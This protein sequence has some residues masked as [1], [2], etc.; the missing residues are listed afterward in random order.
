MQGFRAFP[1]LYSFRL[2]GI[3]VDPESEPQPPAT[4]S[5][6]GLLTVY[7]SRVVGTVRRGNYLR[8]DQIQGREAGWMPHS[9]GLT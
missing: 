2:I 9:E 1:G 5:P 4:R 7:T 8:V 6:P 3:D